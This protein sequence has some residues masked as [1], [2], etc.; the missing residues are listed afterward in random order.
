MH[1]FL[2]LSHIPLCVC[3]TASLSIH[4]PMDI[5]LA[6]MFCCDYTFY[7][8][9]RR[10]T[11]TKPCAKGYNWDFTVD[12]PQKYM[13]Q[14]HNLWA[15]LVAQWV[16]N[17]PAMKE[18]Q[19]QMGLIHLSGKTPGG[20]HGNPLQYSCLESTSHITYTGGMKTIRGNCTVSFK[21]LA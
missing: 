16:K 19:T 2:R 8:I 12:Q 20:G 15:S 13:K 4:L 21:A 17:L 1:S 10:H 18:T 5:Q 3:T 6:S 11:M 9:Q 7:K 14:I